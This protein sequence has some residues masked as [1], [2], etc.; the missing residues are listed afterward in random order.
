MWLRV[1]SHGSNR[2]GATRTNQRLCFDLSTTSTT[3]VDH[4]PGIA[5]NIWRSSAQYID[6]CTPKRHVLP[7]FRVEALVAHPGIVDGRAA[8]STIS[9]SSLSRAT[10]VAHLQAQAEGW[11]E[12]NGEARFKHLPYSTYWRTFTQPRSLLTRRC[13]CGCAFDL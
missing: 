4:A 10:T 3:A 8:K 9:L 5:N 7:T 2:K 13:A 6:A 11:S 1:G 12:R